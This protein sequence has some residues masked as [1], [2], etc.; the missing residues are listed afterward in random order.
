MKKLSFIIILL[1]TISLKA[2]VG[3]SLPSHSNSKWV[4]G[5]YAG[6]SGLIGNSGGMTLHISPRAG[7]KVTQD[8]IAG[9]DGNFSWRS[10]K[11]VSSTILGIGPFVDYYFKRSFY[12]SANL[13][14]YFINSKEKNTK[15]KY[16]SKETALNIGAGYVRR[17]GTSAYIQIG[18]TYN[19]LY[20]KNKSIFGSPFVPHIGIVF[21]L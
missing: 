10:S 3:V 18:G 9:I 12:S 20:N 16:S 19:V 6:L 21:G 15:Y 11:Y 14:Q 4:F 2:Q 17:I 8:L 13:R 1:F 5:G 7:Y